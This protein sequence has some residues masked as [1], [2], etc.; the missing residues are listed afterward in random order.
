MQKGVY[1]TR[2]EL[3]IG[4]IRQIAAQWM[5]IGQQGNGFLHREQIS[6]RLLEANLPE[7]R[8]HQ[9][10]ADAPIVGIKHDRSHAIG[11]EALAQRSHS[12][13][14]IRQ[15]MQNACRNDQVVLTGKRLDRL[16]GQLV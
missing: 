10:H 9:L 16:D 14:R 2:I 15:V 11:T 1:Q 13:G 3:Q 8:L 12:D 6:R 7:N 5:S 4:G